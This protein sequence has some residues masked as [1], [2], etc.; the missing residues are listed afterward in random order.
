MASFNNNNDQ[1]GLPGQYVLQNEDDDISSAASD[2][3][4]ETDSYVSSLDSSELEFLVEA[5]ELDFNQYARHAT[6]SHP[7]P[8]GSPAPTPPPSPMRERDLY[9]GFG[10]TPPSS[11]H[12]S[13]PSDDED[14]DDDDTITFDGP[15][16]NCP[17]WCGCCDVDAGESMRHAWSPCSSIASDDGNDH[18]LSRRN[19]Y[20][21]PANRE[22]V[23]NAE[24]E[25]RAQYVFD[26]VL[27]TFE[28]ETSAHEVETIHYMPLPTEIVLATDPPRAEWLTDFFDSR[29]LD[30]EY[31]R[32]ASDAPLM[33]D[34]N[35]T[36][37]DEV[38]YGTL[39]G[40]CA[41]IIELAL[42]LRTIMHTLMTTADPHRYLAM[43]LHTIEALS[44]GFDNSAISVE[45]ARESMD[46]ECRRL[47]RVNRLFRSAFERSA[48]DMLS[49]RL[50]ER[51][52]RAEYIRWTPAQALSGMRRAVQNMETQQA[53]GGLPP[54]DDIRRHGLSDGP[55]ARLDDAVV[56]FQFGRSVV[57]TIDRRSRPC[58]WRAG[59]SDVMKL[60]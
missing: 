18:F 37:A 39:R 31:L 1:Q 6:R 27:G 56:A 15:P 10:A 45:T 7:T 8:A 58:E 14:D 20:R 36:V 49:L 28:A 9:D 54:I 11:P 3:I 24:I 33:Y 43:H 21:P 35:E 47:Q 30:E 17:E 48:G 23:Y 53:G 60:W 52:M 44:I 34:R 25:E 59:P 57:R 13:D 5:A 41:H 42:Q 29:S 19:V 4:S 46:L 2:T 22:Q 50:R 16:P 12:R 38:R 51:G 55:A 26:T 32:S 40:D